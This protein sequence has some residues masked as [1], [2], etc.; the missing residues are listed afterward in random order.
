MLPFTH[1]VSLKELA[2]LRQCFVKFYLGHLSSRIQNDRLLHGEQPIWPDETPHIELASLKIPTVEQDRIRVAMRLARDLAQDQVVPG[3]I[4]NDQR[5]AALSQLE[6][7]LR[8]WQN[9]NLAGYKFAHAAS[10]SGVF[11]S[12]PRTDSLATNPLKV[13]PSNFS[14]KKRAK[15]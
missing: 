3:K 2:Q 13:S 10:S 1:N 12:R 6:I 4:D 7:G 14:L 5:W 8:K 9:D 11:Q 15:S